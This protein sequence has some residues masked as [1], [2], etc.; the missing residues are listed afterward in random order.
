LRATKKSRR[1]YPR[2]LIVRR[3]EMTT[4]LILLLLIVVILGVK[5]KIRI[6]RR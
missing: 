2:R 5:V 3:F 6:D 4:S 1:E